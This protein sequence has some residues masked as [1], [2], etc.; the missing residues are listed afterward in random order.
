MHNKINKNCIWG[1]ILFRRYATAKMFQLN[2]M[3][4]QENIN[5]KIKLFKNFMLLTFN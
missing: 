2:A 3:E 5:I 4:K 1:Y